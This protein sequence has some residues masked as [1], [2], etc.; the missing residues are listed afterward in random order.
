MRATWRFLAT[1]SLWCL[2]AT[3]H[4]GSIHQELPPQPP[5]RAAQRNRVLLTIVAVTKLEAPYVSHW[6]YYH[7][8][9]G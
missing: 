4:R 8:R 6:L 3:G 5:A 7:Y 2:S 1:W 9:L